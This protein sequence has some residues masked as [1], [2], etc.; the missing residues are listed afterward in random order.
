MQT[1]ELDKAREALKDGNL[2]DAVDQQEKAAFEL[3]RLANELEAATARARDPREAARQLE[4]LQEEFRRQAAALA[5]DGPIASAPRDV[6]ERF[7]Q[8]GK[9]QRALE[10]AVR[11]LSIPPD[12]A[13]AETIRKVAAELAHG[14][15][16]AIGAHDEKAADEAMQKARDA[17]G[18]LVEQ[19]PT[20]EKRLAA[21]RIEL[22]KLRQEQDAIAALVDK[23]IKPF[24]KLDPDAADTQQELAAG[25]RTS[26][27]GKP[28]R[29]I[30]W[31]SSTCPA[32][33]S[34]PQRLKKRCARPRATSTAAG[35][36]TPAPRSRPPAGNSNASNR[37]SPASLPPTS[38]P[39]GSPKSRRTWPNK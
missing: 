32:T 10:R 35:L 34:A 27:N 9:R 4:R 21:S 2:A 13:A 18:K 3:E 28:G 6:R 5:K 17:L 7:E 30:A 24:E 29:P 39:T 19:M 14:A 36:K 15:L 25:R 12:A 1:R 11:K 23:A 38:R 16:V 37:Q 33:R 22:A 31:P 26:P 8:L 20:Q